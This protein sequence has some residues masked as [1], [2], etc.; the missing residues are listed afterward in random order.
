MM[1]KTSIWQSLKQVVSL[2]NK[3]KMQ[4][5]LIASILQLA[6]TVIGGNGLNY[7]FRLA[8]IS[9][10][11]T[12]LNKNN[13]IE[14]LL[15]PVSAFMI[16]VFVLAFAALFFI[17]ISILI[18]AI[19]AL[20]QE[21]RLSYRGVIRQAT[22]KIKH[23]IG[24]DFIY[25][26]LYTI[27][28]VPVYGIVMSSTLTQ[29]L[30]IPD[31]ITGEFMKSG[32]GMIGIVVVALLLIYLNIK[33]I[34]A[35]PA[36]MIKNMTL[37]K[38][39]R[40]SWNKTKKGKF[41]FFMTVLLFELFLGLISV[42]T[43]LLCTVPMVFI[44]SS[45][46]NLVMQSIFLTLIQFV[47]F[48]FSVLS[49]IGILTLLVSNM[50]HY[51]QPDTLYLTR[52][53]QKRSIMLTAGI[54][55]TALL[56]I[57]GNM[58]ELQDLQLNR[59]EAIIGHR[60]YVKGGVENSLE[61]LEAAAAQGVQFVELDILMTKDQQFVVMH[62]NQ[63][64]RLAGIDQRVQDMTAA[65]VVG[66]P[67]EQ[68]GFTSKIPSFEEFVQRAKELN[69][70][71]LVELKPHGGEPANY[72]ELFVAKMKELGVETQYRVMSL[73]L[74]TILAV[75]QQ[76]PEMVTGY[77]IPIQFGAFERQAVDFF[78]IEDFSYNSSLAEQAHEMQKELYVW[79]IN[80]YAK[81]VRYLQLPIDGIISDELEEVTEAKQELAQ[82]TSYY[83]RVM[84]LLEF[85]GVK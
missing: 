51:V 29:H 45:G 22:A 20:Q 69:V 19:Y 67:I 85:D 43:L 9:A 5:I 32:K 34:Y 78:V 33:L 83:D 68:E 48:F 39:I 23:L 7:L 13:L 84:R 36:M 63:L 24:L 79:T 28:T 15:N 59:N 42:I 30:T 71:L 40:Y 44:D 46:N 75:E 65:E 62:D 80:D 52:T 72:V 41:K 37:S 55:V 56:A 17:E 49:K 58:L 14:L 53:E 8:L 26:I 16:V 2:L 38:S 21:K 82:N 54:I 74:P 61:A 70:K 73:D 81:I 12:N 18:Y 64:K 66:L 27:V 76:A 3:N 35:I 10:N 50:S 1:Q 47:T 31:F 25:F 60:G 6:I 11:Q 57:V 4:F 77:I